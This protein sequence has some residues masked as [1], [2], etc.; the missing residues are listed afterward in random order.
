MTLGEG[1]AQSVTGH[2]VDAADNSDTATVDGINVDETAP[3][4]TG[5]PTTAPNANGWY[6]GD[7]T[8]HWT[9]SDALSGLDGPCPADS[10]ITGE[11]DSLSA[12]ASIDDQ[13]GNHS[14][15]TVDGIKIDRV[16]PTTTSDAPSRLAERRRRP[17]A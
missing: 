16:A 10:V 9:C 2:A 17:S 7:V 14:S 4:I 1:A 12:T 15:A 11:G 6:Q 13:A 3:T 8:V 5:A